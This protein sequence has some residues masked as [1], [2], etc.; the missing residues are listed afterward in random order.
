MSI[1]NYKYNCKHLI[2]SKNRSALQLCPSTSPLC[3][4]TCG[5]N[6]ALACFHK[7]NLSLCLLQ[8][9][10]QSLPPSLQPFHPPFFGLMKSS[11]LQKTGDISDFKSKRRMLWFLDLIAHSKSYSKGKHHQKYP[12]VESAFLSHDCW[13]LE[14]YIQAVEV[15]EA[16][17]HKMPPL[18]GHCPNSNYTPPPPHSNGHSGA[19]F[20]RRDFTIFFTI[21][22]E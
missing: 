1:L 5:D 21:F 3:I 17:F 14:K 9:H 7:F 8:L 18:F 10:C 20:F 4:L 13:S 19:L 22:S 2:K 12:F 6:L 15:R 11:G 16:P